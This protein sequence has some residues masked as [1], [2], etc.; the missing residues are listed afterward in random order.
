MASS[1]AEFRQKNP[2]YDN[3]P[4]GKLLYGLY[5]HPDFK[6]VPL[7]KFANAMDLSSEQKMEFLKSNY[8]LFN[9]QKTNG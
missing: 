6:D 1:L 8:K 5:N 9:S 7:M 2:S 3:V 4:D